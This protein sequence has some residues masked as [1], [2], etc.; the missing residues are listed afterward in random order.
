MKKTS[1]YLLTALSIAALSSCVKEMTPEEITS[2]QS[3]TYTIELAPTT[4]TDITA[5]GKTVWK[6]GDKIL[7]TDGTEKDTVVVSATDDGKAFAT[8]ESCM[9]GT[10]VFAIYPA[11]AAASNP[12]VDGK[13]NV[14]VP[15]DQSGLFA[16]ANIAVAKVS[17][18]KFQMKN[19]T[20]VMKV[21]TPADGLYV[22]FN[23]SGDALAGNIAVSFAEDGTI[24]T[25]A[26]GTNGIVTCEAPTADSY[27]VAVAAG[28]YKAGFSIMA[29]DGATGDFQTKA[30]TADKSLAVNDLADLGTI[31]DNM[32]GF[33][34]AGDEGDPYKITSIGEMIALANSTNIGNDYAG[35]Y[36]KV[37]NDISGVSLPVG[38][39]NDATKVDYYFKGNFDGCNHTITLDLDAARCKSTS[40]VALFGN[41]GDG[42]NIHDVIVDGTVSGG[43][44]SAGI[45]GCLNSGTKGVTIK[46]CTNKATINGT[47]QVG[48]IIG[49]A[50]ASL[51][52]VFVIEDCVNDGTVT[53]TSTRVGGIVG[54]ST[55]AK[56]K[57]IR[58]CTNN[59][60]VTGS[61][62][63]GGIIGYS[64]YNK[65]SG[66][67]NTGEVVGSSDQ[68]TCVYALVGGSF[69]V[70]DNN[71]T[72]AVGGISG[73]TQNESV[74]SCTNSGKV[75]GCV[76]VGGICGVNYWCSIT[77]CS[78]TGDIN[79]RG[80][81]A[82]NWA[83]ANGLNYGSMA[84][85]IV[86]WLDGAGNITR[87]NN[88]GKITG[89]AGTGGIVGLAQACSASSAI[90]AIQNCKNEGEIYAEGHTG[91]SAGSNA[92]AGGIAG[93]VWNQNTKTYIKVISCENTANVTN[94]N[95]IAGGI[96]GM[97]Y[98]A[99]NSGLGLVDKCVNW[100]DVTTP[101]WVGGIVGY[102]RSRAT[103][104]GAT[105]RNCENHGTITGTRPDDA[106]EC[107]GGIVGANNGSSK[108]FI[109]N[110]YNDGEVFYK[111]TAHVKPYCGGII[112]QCV[113]TAGSLVQ[114]C[115]NAAYVGPLG[116][117]E[118]AEGAQAT[119]G[120]I[121]GNHGLENALSCS[122]SLESACAQ[123]VGTGSKTVGQNVAS[124]TDEGAFGAVPTVNSKDCPTLLEALNAWVNGNSTYFAWQ[125][126]AFFP[127][128]VKE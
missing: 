78:N 81:Y 126:G 37:M 34:G 91:G 104:G 116:K 41:V 120:G 28:T 43:S 92:G 13:V 21:S 59:G 101:Y 105:V 85:G 73:W 86:G 32:S 26:S 95:K 27:Y 31:G 44:S 61:N 48:G 14:V 24:T 96:V 23:A 82:Y 83:S 33:S 68:A 118:P 114:N 49:Y 77:D 76:K 47:T 103:G 117:G 87:C 110:C 57:I 25:E 124:F 89:M 29:V 112:G 30:T 22:V 107:A 100:G 56:T 98:D 50:D 109:Y 36:F 127:E 115:Y 11:S 2:G 17:D 39:Y 69:K 99:N 7:L 74:T 113:P 66:C 122:Y 8:I 70:P 15:A 55:T 51:E 46:N 63:V 60:K 123:L 19:A 106:G 111:E 93:I 6:T 54:I 72:N 67:T 45:V 84:G 62:N 53:G 108:H 128:F 40:Y 58:N 79:G 3:R 121:V 16:D 64:Y 52:N 94:T 65:I 80:E 5:E 125:E 1:Y 10:E 42:A 38:Y 9:A 102:D 12:V 20:A 4:R 90:P 75:E 18:Y 71:Y 119:L 35:K 88:S 97:T